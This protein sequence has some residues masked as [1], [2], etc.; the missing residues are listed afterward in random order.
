MTSEEWSLKGK[1]VDMVRVTDDKE[2]TF[3]YPAYP[4]DMLYSAKDIEILHRELQK[5]KQE[6]QDKI[7]SRIAGLLLPPLPHKYINP[8][9]T[10]QLRLD[11]SAVINEEF[12]KFEEKINKRFGVK[13]D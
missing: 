5:D 4:L 11:I 3:G 7:S 13:N 12:R 6:L 10:S 9:N 1:D 2:D 8:T